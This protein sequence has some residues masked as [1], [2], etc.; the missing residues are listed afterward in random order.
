MNVWVA[1]MATVAVTCLVVI[2]ILGVLAFRPQRARNVKHAERQ[3]ERV[4]Q[5]HIVELGVRH[6]EI[7]K[8]EGA[9]TVIPSTSPPTSGCSP[10]RCASSRG[11]R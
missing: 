5:Q 6:P 2:P 1:V 10:T 4:V 7:V 3:T 8:T 11:H 9:S